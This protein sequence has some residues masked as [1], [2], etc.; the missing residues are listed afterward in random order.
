MPDNVEIGQVLSNRRTQYCE[1]LVL[2]FLKNFAFQSLK[3]DTDRVII[4]V[5]PPPVARSA[6]MP[7]PLLSADKLPELPIALNI[8]V[9]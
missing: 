8:K 6:R 1:A 7:G 2:R 9:R 3:F 4:A 5:V